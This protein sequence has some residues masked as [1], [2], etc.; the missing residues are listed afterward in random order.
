M[1]PELWTVL[2]FLFLSIS[3]V[4][5]MLM[6]AVRRNHQAVAVAT[7]IGLLAALIAI[8]PATP[9]VPVMVTPLFL[10]DGFTL[11]F[12]ALMIMASIAVLLLSYTYLNQMEEGPY[13]E[14]YLLLLLATLGAA[15]LLASVHFVSF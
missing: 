9:P 5:V 11:F 8:I 4:M 13:E 15:A 3:A 7:F 14:Y 2:P 10:V 6:I 12:L 1:S